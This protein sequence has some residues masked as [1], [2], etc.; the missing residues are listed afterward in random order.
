LKESEKFQ[1]C[2]PVLYE[3]GVDLFK[4][5][6]AILLLRDPSEPIYNILQS[7]PHLQ[8]GETLDWIIPLQID[9]HNQAISTVNLFLH[10]EDF[11]PIIS[12]L[13]QNK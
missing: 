12:Q 13:L 7:K 5:A 10:N 11:S 8:D 2:S 6:S 1:F 4:T 9:E 3:F